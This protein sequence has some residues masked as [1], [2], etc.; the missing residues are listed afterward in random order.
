MRTVL[1]TA[2]VTAW[3]CLVYYMGFKDGWKRG[4]R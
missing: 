1:V 4:V 3:S 2:I